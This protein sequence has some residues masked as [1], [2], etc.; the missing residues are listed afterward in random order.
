[1]YHDCLEFLEVISGDNRLMFEST[2]VDFK[3]MS[4]RFLEGWKELIWL[5][6]ITLCI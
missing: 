5:V 4:G 2:E 1:M 6:S 3:E